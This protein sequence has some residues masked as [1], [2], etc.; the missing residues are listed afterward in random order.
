[1]KLLNRF[2]LG[3]VFNFPLYPI[4]SRHSNFLFSLWRTTS[5]SRVSRCRSNGRAFSFLS[6]AVFGLLLR[7][8]G[9]NS[10]LACW[11]LASS[12]LLIH[13]SGGFYFRHDICCVR[14]PGFHAE[15]GS[16][17]DPVCV[18]QKIDGIIDS[19][20]RNLDLTCCLFAWSSALLSLSY[21]W[22]AVA[23][24]RLSSVLCADLSL[25]GF[26]QMLLCCRV[27]ALLLSYRYSGLVR[28]GLALLTLGIWI[29]T[30][31]QILGQRWICL[32]PLL[33]QNCAVWWL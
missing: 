24:L 20:L 29:C 5:L 11:I 32:L 33:W 19:C 7:Y 13:L 28:C 25:F 2:L 22:F 23:D 12:L 1:M 26:L 4:Y 3:S 30:C 14:K 21:R 16:G 6:A 27:P 8:L 9:L 17:F 31:V 15:M 18:A 10:P